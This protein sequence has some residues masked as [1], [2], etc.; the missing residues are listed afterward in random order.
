MAKLDGA[1]VLVIGG[2]SGVGFAVAAAA[3]LAGADVLVGSS[4]TARIE[5]AAEKLGARGQTVDVKDEAPATGATCSAQPAISTSRQA[6]RAWKCASGARP[7]PPNTPSARSPR[8][9]LS[10]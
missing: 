6:R 1:K 10:P 3:K 5:A 2:A 9:A 8:M 7:G 4:Q